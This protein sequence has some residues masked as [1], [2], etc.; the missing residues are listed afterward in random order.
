M[1]RDRECRP[2]GWGYAFESTDAYDS[3]LGGHD[4]VVAWMRAAF[5]EGQWTTF[6]VAVMT[7]FTDDPQIAIAFKLRWC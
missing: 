2:S 6:G 1:V 5:P 4:D 3:L 7:V